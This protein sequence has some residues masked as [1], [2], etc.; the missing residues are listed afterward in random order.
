MNCNLCFIAGSA[1]GIILSLI[2]CF[3]WHRRRLELQ[4]K[5]ADLEKQ[6]QAYHYQKTI[7][8]ATEERIRALHHD[9]KNHFLV[10]DQLA[11]EGRCREIREY[12]Y[13]TGAEVTGYN[14]FINT[15][16]TIIDGLVNSKLES[17]LAESVEIETEVFISENLNIAAGD[18]S[19]ILGNL[20]DNAVIALKEMPEG[21][22]Q[23]VLQ[24]RMREDRG[25]L[26]LKITNSHNR[27]LC[28]SG[29]FYRTSKKDRWRHGIGLKNVKSVVDRYAGY[30][31]ISHTENIFA[32]EI[33][34]F[35]E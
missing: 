23:K 8:K 9:L 35:L 24:L 12:I 34:L 15:G 13:R 10:L 32:V 33:V 6:V 29:G 18:I 22:K 7:R 3:Y 25:Q 21:K 26:I 30:M 5:I 14:T 19:I 28:K 17:L 11:K 27:S 31:E 16:N 2:L 20:L 4:L 1:G